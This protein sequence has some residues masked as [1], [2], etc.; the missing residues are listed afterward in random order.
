MKFAL[1]DWLFLASF[2]AVLLA[3]PLWCARRNKGTSSDFFKGGGTMPWWLIGISMVAAMTSTNSANLFT[4][5]IRENG[6]SGN[7]VWW[8]FLTGGILTVFV[9]AKLWHRLG[10]MTDIAFYE[11]R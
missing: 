11:L 4:Q 9:Y 1:I 8:A 3:I 6:M 5:L 7:W 10:A 2:F